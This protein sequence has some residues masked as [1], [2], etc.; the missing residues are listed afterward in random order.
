MK[1]KV[2]K[3]KFDFNSTKKSLQVSEVNWTGYVKLLKI[4]CEIHITFEC[5]QTMRI[6]AKV[7]AYTGKFVPNS[8]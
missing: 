1:E 8:Q 6:I 3:K 5:Y 4:D 7:V 2:K